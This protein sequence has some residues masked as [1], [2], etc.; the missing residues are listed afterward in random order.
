MTKDTA[1]KVL[2]LLILSGHDGQIVD[3]VKDGRFVVETSDMDGV[4]VEITEYSTVQDIFW[5]MGK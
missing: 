2:S 1:K 5:I 4:L 3:H